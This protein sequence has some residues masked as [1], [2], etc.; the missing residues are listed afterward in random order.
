MS[1]DAAKSE[2]KVIADSHGVQEVAARRDSLRDLSDSTASS[3]ETRTDFSSEFSPSIVSKDVH[4]KAF[5]WNPPVQE[6]IPIRTQHHN[7]RLLPAFLARISSFTSRGTGIALP[8]PV[9]SNRLAKRE[10]VHKSSNISTGI[11]SVARPSN[12]DTRAVQAL[13]PSHNGDPSTTSA[14]VREHQDA[15][16]SLDNSQRRQRARR[17]S[18]VS[19]VS[20]LGPSGTADAPVGKERKMHQTS[21]RLL[22]MTDDDRPFT[23][24]R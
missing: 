13:L 12:Q 18:S 5:S 15:Q 21:S 1:T 24:V 14:T 10:V 22:R 7:T 20:S 6:A 19:F 3:D 23:R 4:E 8:S 9:P 16:Y 17:A 2:P 11:G